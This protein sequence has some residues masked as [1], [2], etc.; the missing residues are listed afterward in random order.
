MTES[1][2]GWQTGWMGHLLA[3]VSEKP[4]GFAWTV[5]WIGHLEGRQGWK[6]I[7]VE[8]TSFSAPAI[9]VAQLLLHGW[10]GP[11]LHKQPPFNPVGQLV[12][13]DRPICHQ[14]H[15]QQ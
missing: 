6:E 11:A 2:S 9:P 13:S 5:H 15:A 14:P 7:M 3:V 1:K 8:E 12:P 10:G 4:V